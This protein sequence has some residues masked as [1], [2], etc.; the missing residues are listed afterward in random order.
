MFDGAWAVRKAQ[1]HLDTKRKYFW[2]PIGLTDSCKPPY[3]IER[4]SSGRAVSTLSAESSL[5]P[6]CLFLFV[7]VADKT[8]LAV[9]I[10]FETFQS[11][12]RPC[13]KTIRKKIKV[14]IIFSLDML[15]LFFLYL[16]FC[17]GP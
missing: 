5:Q 16:F 9:Q 3:G 17:D 7:I 1:W 10:K 4:G 13:I 8:F 15:G 14:W 12:I 2:D 11:N 6:Q